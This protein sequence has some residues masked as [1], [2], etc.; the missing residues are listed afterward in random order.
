MGSIRVATGTAIIIGTT[1]I[2]V[3]GAQGDIDRGRFIMAITISIS[4][5]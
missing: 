2:M 4:I 1:V 3:D 5:I